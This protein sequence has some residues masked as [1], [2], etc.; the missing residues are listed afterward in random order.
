MKKITLLI[1]ALF[2][3]FSGFAQFPT[4]GIEGFEGTSG[5]DLA[6]PTTPS[7]WTLGTGVTG[8]QWAVFDNGVGLN[9]RWTINNGTVTPP[10]PPL[11]YAGTNAAYMNRENIGINNTSE[12]YLATP[13]ITVPANGQLRF[14]SRTF[15]LGNQGTIYQVKVNTVAGTQTNTANYTTLLAEYTEDQLTLNP[16][17]VQQDYN[18][19]TEKVIDFPAALIG[20]QVYVAFVMKFTQTTTGIGG[21]R[22]L[23]DD[24]RVDEKCLNPTTLTA[25]GLL[26]NQATLS[27]ANP[28]GSSSWE[29]EV[30]PST[31]T[32]TGVG[33]VYNGSL[34]YVVTGLTANTCYKYYVR[35]ICSSGLNSEW[36]G[37]FNFCTTTA[38]PV[39]G[40][41]FVD[42]GGPTANYAN[43]SDVT[44]TIC[45]TIPGELVTVTFT[46][47]QVETNWDALYVFDG[48]GI[49]APQIASANPAAN[50]P[51]GL[52]G[53]FWGTANP[54]PFT[55]SAAN[56]C[57]TFRFRSD[58]SVNQAGWVAN[59]TCAPAPTCPKPT[60]LVTSA[61]TPNSVN[62]AWTNPSS[63]TE[64]NVLALPCGS[65]IPNAST[66]GWVVANTN[67]FTLGGLNPDTCYTLY[68]RNV[69]STS[70][71]SEWSSSVNILTQ[72][73]PPACGGIFTDTGGSTANYA[74][75]SDSTITIC[76][77]VAGEVVTVTFNSFNVQANADGLYIFNGNTI[78]APIFSS[79]NPAGT[80]PGGLAGA[81]WG[82]ANPGSFT[83]SSTNGCLTFR[84]RSGAA[85]NAAGWVA[86]VTCAPAPTCPKPLSL[87]TSAV[88]ATSVNLAWTEAATATIWHVLAIPCG[89]P[90][91]TAAS[92]GWVVANT[93]PFVLNSLN[94]ETCYDIYVRSE[95]SSSDFSNW[96]GPRTITTLIAPPACGGVYTDLGGAAANYPNGADSTVIICPTTAGDQ[97]TVTFTSFNVET[98]WDALYVFDGN[99]LAAPQIATTNPAANV[100]GGLAGGF[101][102]TALPGPFTASS[103]SGCLTFRFRSDASVSL[104]GW[105]A[106]VTCAPPPTCPKPTAV[107]VG[108]ITQNS[109][110]ISWTEIG[111]AT[112]WQVLVVPV[113][114]P[115]PDAT[116]TGWLTA[117]TNPFIYPGLNSGTQYKVYVRS[118]CSETDISLWS[119][120]V[121]FNTLISNDECSTAI[122]APV[123]PDTTCAQVVGGTVIGAT[124]STQGNTCGGTDDDDVW[125]QFTATT[126]AHSIT[127]QNITGS[128]T[129]LF[130]VLY[131]GTCGALTQLY[132][133]DANESTATGL[134]VGQT[135]YIRVYTWTATPNQTS[136]FNLC[137]GTIPPPITTNTTQYTA[138]QLVQDVLLN[139]TCAQVT[140][141]TFS[142]GTNFGSTNGIGYF[143]QNGSG[144]PFSEGVILTT[145]NV[146][147]APGPNTEGLSDGNATWPGD[148]QL[149]NYIQGLGIDPGLNSYNN[150]TILEFDFVPL[151]DNISF[152]FIFAS[153]EY[154]VFQCT[155][156]DAFA[157]FLTNNNTGVTT[158]LA[159]LPSTTIP[160][161]VVTIR[162]NLYNNGCTSANPQYFA[163]YYL[164]PGLSPLG[165]P[166][167]FNG[168]TVPL[169]ATSPVIPGT[170][171][172]IKLVIADRNDSAFDSAVFLNGGSFN[173]G[174]IELG[175]DFLVNNG[176]ALC[177]GDTQVISSDL[178][179]DSYTFSWT[180]NGE[181]IPN[182]TTPTIT[183]S[184]EGV[185]TLTAT[186]IGTTC[187]SSD[188]VTVE[189]YDAVE[190]NTGQNL[191]ECNSLGYSLFDLTLN[192][193][194]IL[195]SLNSADYTITYHL[196]Q[197]DAESGSNAISSPFTNTIQFQQ[198]IYV[199]VRNSVSNC[200]AVT[201]FDIIVQDLTPQFTITPNFSICQGTSGTITVTPINYNPGD[202]T[203]SWT[204]D[205]NVLN[206]T[207]NSI[208]VTLAG[209]YEVV[210]NNS[211]CT[212]IGTTI[213]TITPIPV[214]DTPADVTECNSYTLPSLS[215]G[216]YYTGMNGSGTLLPAGT[217]IT[218]SQT[219]YV[220]AQSNTTPN[221]TA[222]N[223]F[224]VTII[225][226]TNPTF[227]PIA[228]ICQDFPTVTLPGTS[229]NGITGIWS[230]TTIDTSVVGTVTYTFTPDAGQC[231]NVA[232]L[233]VTIDA[234][235][236]VPTFNAVPTIC[237][238]DVAPTL[239]TTSLNGITGSWSST[240]DTSVVGTTAYTFTPNAA[241][242]AV[243]T[244]LNVTVVA[245]TLASFTQ[246]A[247]ICQ[248][249]TAP[250]LPS[251]SNNGVAGIWNPATINTSVAGSAT[252]IFTPN[253]GLCATGTT[254]TVVVHPTPVVAP[255]TPVVSCVSYTL[256]N[257]TNGNYYTGTG[258]TGTQLAVGTVIS[259][260][261]TIYVFDQSG[262]TP[263]CTAE[264]ELDITINPAP[265][266]SVTGGCDGSIY[267]LEVVSD[268]FDLSSATYAWT[269]S[270]GQPVG[271][272]SS[273]LN[274][275]TAGN[276]TCQV[277]VNGCSDSY[278]FS[279]NT[280]TCLV[281]KGISPNGDG[282]NDNFDLTGFNVRQLNIFNRYGSK[283]YSRT[284][285]TN[286]WFGQSDKEEELPDGT[287]YYVIERNDSSETKTGWIYINRE[288]K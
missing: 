79:G 48:N 91:P 166:I 26:F 259:S 134:V 263:N 106:N 282:Q 275:T 234:P 156:S 59:V 33:V 265:Q 144:F 54:G 64:W 165:A 206:E 97:V 149:F 194:S 89:S 146:N 157:F 18:I 37:P 112:S 111:S 201:Q 283:V 181:T 125:F 180:L 173:I 63:A 77:T 195:G 72:Q 172:H 200:F 285:Y 2:L 87:T 52:A 5:A 58:A 270:T 241:Q 276:Y 9:Q 175:G 43:S 182:A 260:S 78:A 120:P 160:I 145:G 82:T 273:T 278:L 46:A 215:V 163:N 74:N 14:Y 138:T 250:T 249:G 80:V 20:Q 253:A 69:C 266:F 135:Y 114:A 152:D 86:N 10:T 183:I 117:T 214:P 168:E 236:I 196:S 158:N 90:F 98:N 277:T 83:S 190:I 119:V 128:T 287:Y 208:T 288:N 6:A 228:N 76:P 184:G 16:Q 179:P 153:E 229:T 68:V 13:L 7:P 205:G 221:C 218:T 242:C 118:F 143:N 252:Y 70:D 53:G 280:I 170:Q 122:V 40:G 123:N 222:E 126:T 188:S 254:M 233:N 284:N 178:D 66:T 191:V 103:A 240:I 150:A 95:C 15:T 12:D 151:T 84:F 133:S 41:N 102:G 198:T 209:N 113:S 226:L 248:G 258:G 23:L 269:N 19:Y 261:Q 31:A 127:L 104:A 148:A 212:A 219:I 49:T 101:W 116:T 47:F 210:V 237:L 207:G 55:S 225:P 93:N 162:D 44:V 65:P 238:N 164:A 60:A 129:D 75:N 137:I 1:L 142:T 268:S 105:V 88:T 246:I 217:V 185:Y 132:C 130:H 202:V 169:T 244:T 199:R 34:P 211:G 136:V 223:S 271:T 203:Y 235:S 115:T 56:G 4:P 286:Q 73:V 85:T 29:V 35:S 171:Y 256:P 193:T 96:Y 187:G 186:Y 39:C 257:L 92:T 204:L 22:W 232:S 272:N 176:T 155:F 32:P 224:D 255:Q 227:N 62:I 243:V 27:W 38:P 174:N 121:T 140:N 51:G 154:G 17:G 216:D 107:A 61:I 147:R 8:N 45:P 57:L 50:V 30:I 28:S 109:A 231:A 67:P 245:P 11:V 99:S 141:V 110:S 279:A 281:P 94:P 239:P 264:Q 71:I 274:V 213:L 81:F 220:F 251:T 167:D 262:T 21:D 100:P 189:Y 197:A 161:S 108:S 139:T 42:A 267:V 3:S 124:P 24:V 177:A 25:T 230:P 131:S 36:V 247:P 192:N 159:V